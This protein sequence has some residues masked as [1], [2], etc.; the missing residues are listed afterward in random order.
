MREAII[1]LPNTP[2][3]RGAQLKRA[4]GQFYF[5]FTYPLQ[6]C[7]TEAEMNYA[8]SD[9]FKGPIGRIYCLSRRGQL[10]MSGP[11]SSWLGE[12]PANLHC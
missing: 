7:F 2:S 6:Q 1:P 10:T 12:G 5:N 3:W 11:S 4:K 8:L 9:L